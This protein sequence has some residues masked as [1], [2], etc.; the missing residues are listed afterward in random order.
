M[1]LPH[2]SRLWR[3]RHLVG[4]Y[5]NVRVDVVLV[6]IESDHDSIQPGLE[7]PPQPQV[8]HPATRIRRGSSLRYT[9]VGTRHHIAAQ[10][11]L[12]RLAS[13]GRHLEWL[14]HDVIR[15]LVLLEAFHLSMDR[16]TI[17]A[18][19]DPRDVCPARQRIVIIRP[20]AQRIARVPEHLEHDRL[21][22]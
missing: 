13:R 15:A 10:R 14:P 11:Y 16:Q 6:E 18:R 9:A 3:I 17:L 7:S 2:G 5:L 19:L 12:C 20:E 1:A 4:D 21:L 8:E 22:G